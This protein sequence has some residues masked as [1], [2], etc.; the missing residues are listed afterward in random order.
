MKKQE[1]LKDLERG[2]KDREADIKI[3]GEDFV[4]HYK[5]KTATGVRYNICSVDDMIKHFQN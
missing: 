3:F 2:D 5:F 1:L 4:N